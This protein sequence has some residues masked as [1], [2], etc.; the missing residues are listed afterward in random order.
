LGLERLKKKII[1]KTSKTLELSWIYHAKHDKSMT[2]TV[3]VCNCPEQPTGV[4]APV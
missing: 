2:E 4:L 3:M 1:G